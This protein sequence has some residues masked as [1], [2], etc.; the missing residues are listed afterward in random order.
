MQNASQFIYD[1]ESQNFQEKVIQS[2]F[3]HLVLVDFWAPW[4]APCRMLKPILER[5]A[6]QMDGDFIL[7]KLNTEDHPDLAS[8]FGIRGIPNVKFFKNGQIVDEFA[9]VIS[10]EEIQKKIKNYMVSPYDNF[11]KSLTQLDLN[12]KEQAFRDQFEQF[13][14]RSDYRLAYAK[15][16]FELNSFDKIPELL[17]EIAEFQNEYLEAGQLLS[18]VQ[19]VLLSLKSVDKAVDKYEGYLIA[20][21]QKYKANNIQGALD[22]LLEVLYRKKNYQNGFAKTIVIALIAKL[23]DPELSESYSRRLSMAINA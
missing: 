19:F 12:Q 21:A 7:A 3:D 23:A 6:T 15:I 9:G 10:E 16:L 14:Q 2:S 20:A 11:L 17:S 18:L 22:E 13:S 5:I 8:Q 4:C 1:V